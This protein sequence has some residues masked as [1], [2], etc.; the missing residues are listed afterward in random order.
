MAELHVGRHVSS[1]VHS[2]DALCAFGLVCVEQRAHCAL[3]T[4]ILIGMHQAA[5][6][7]SMLGLHSGRHVS[8]ELLIDHAHHASGSA[9]VE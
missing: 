7:I 1:V 2:V 4:C 6:S 9:C 5:C 8:I 3:P